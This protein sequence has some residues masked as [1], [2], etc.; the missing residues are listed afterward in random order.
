MNTEL[1]KLEL[2]RERAALEARSR[3]LELAQLKTAVGNAR[4]RSESARQ[5]ISELRERAREELGETDLK[6]RKLS[7]AVGDVVAEIDRLRRLVEVIGPVNPLAPRQ[8]RDEARRVENLGLQIDDMEKSAA[9]LKKISTEL[10]RAVRGEFMNAFEKMRCSCQKYFG[11]LVEGGDARMSL[12]DPQHPDTSGIEIDVRIPGKRRQPLNA[13]SGGERAL[14]SAALLFAMIDYKS[15]P[16]CVLDEVDAALDE[17]NILRFQTVLNDF[18]DRMQLILITHNAA[19]IERASS[20]FG[21]VM[22]AD[23]IS[24]VVSVRLNGAEHSGLR[25]ESG[26]PARN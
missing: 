22:A 4:D 12:A 3:E 2:E 8:Y 11:S 18:K 20:V 1:R 25:R 19:S 21:V 14:V 10:E 6:P 23:G 5:R 17:S 9:E 26:V 24:Q 15:G 16:I 13:L 7:A